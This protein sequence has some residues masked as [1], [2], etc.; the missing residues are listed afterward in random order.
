[1]KSN[2]VRVILASFLGV[3]WLLV[4]FLN[5]NGFLVQITKVL[6]YIISILFLIT[7]LPD[8]KYLMKRNAVESV[9]RFK[10]FIGNIYRYIFVFLSAVILFYFSVNLLCDPFNSDGNVG[11]CLLEKKI[12]IN[13]KGLLNVNSFRIHN[14]G[15]AEFHFDVY[16]KVGNVYKKLKVS[17]VDGVVNCELEQT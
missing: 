13:T 4:I 12:V 15:V 10:L 16:V 5:F 8:F 1:M 7:I 3:V 9:E 6:F 17:K 2:V 11:Q 14:G